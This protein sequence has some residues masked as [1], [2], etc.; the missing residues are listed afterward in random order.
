VTA[1]PVKM[2]AVPP[3][4]VQ[5]TESPPWKLTPVMVRVNAVAPAP[6]LEGL[7]LVTDGCGATLKDSGLELTPLEGS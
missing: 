7:M 4:G 5:I 6:A 2:V 3:A 1:L